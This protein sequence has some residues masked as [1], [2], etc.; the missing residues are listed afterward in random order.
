VLSSLLLVLASC[1]WVTWIGACT[2]MMHVWRDY[3]VC[4]SA[5]YNEKNSHRVQSAAALFFLLLLVR[6]LLILPLLLLQAAAAGG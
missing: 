3:S 4:R 5:V 2:V 6:V 1:S